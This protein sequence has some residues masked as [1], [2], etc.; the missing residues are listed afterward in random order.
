MPS[1][2]ELAAQKSAGQQAH[3]TTLVEELG[4][5]GKAPSSHGRRL[6][7]EIKNRVADQHYDLIVLE[8]H[9]PSLEL[10]KFYQSEVIKLKP[11]KVGLMAEEL[12]IW[13]KRSEPEFAD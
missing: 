2:P 11:A 6:L 5:Y 7:A 9:Q 10:E 3:L 13:S 8:Q 4:G 12:L 1:F